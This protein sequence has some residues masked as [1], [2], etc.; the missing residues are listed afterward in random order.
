MTSS[1]L[2]PAGESGG[3]LLRVQ[4]GVAAAVRWVGLLPLIAGGAL[5]LLLVVVLSLQVLFRYA[6][7][8]PL[9]WTEES[10]RYAL[11]WLSM[12]AAVVAAREGQHFVFRWITLRLPP[13][14][15][16]WVRRACDLFVMVLLAV[17]IWQ[18]V[19]YLGVV[20]NRTSPGTGLNMRWPYAGVT[21]G[22][23]FLLILYLLENVDAMLS[24]RT[25]VVLSARELNEAEVHRMFE[26]A[27]GGGTD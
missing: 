2:G 6:I 15:R 9:A 16:F 25:G 23:A 14:V 5:L 1:T 24:L 3:P 22:S 26:A 20:A 13:R 19:I 18:S 7:Q 12:L 27:D 8:Q 17:I 4:Q 11:V 21:V 10:A